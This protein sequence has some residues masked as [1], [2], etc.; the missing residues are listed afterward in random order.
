MVSTLQYEEHTKPWSIECK[1]LQISKKTAKLC[2]SLER[3]NTTDLQRKKYTKMFPG[4]QITL[5]YKI[6][7]EISQI[8]G[9]G[10]TVFSYIYTVKGNIYIYIYTYQR[11]ALHTRWAF[12]SDWYISSEELSI[13][14]QTDGATRY[15]VP[16]ITPALKYK[17]GKLAAKHLLLVF[18]IISPYLSINN[19]TLSEIR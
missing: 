13:S 11:E 9:I 3:W 8:R 6:K 10:R 4:N 17:K 14:L 15:E 19:K 1:E 12:N 16:N 2:S 7:L 5:W 18:T